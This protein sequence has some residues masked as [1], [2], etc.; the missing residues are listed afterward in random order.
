[1]TLIKVQQRLI[2]QMK[3]REGRDHRVVEGD[4]GILFTALLF[5]RAT[6]SPLK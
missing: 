6:R 5:V 1:M 2:L 3:H 4:R